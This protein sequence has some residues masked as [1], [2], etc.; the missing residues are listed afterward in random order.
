MLNRTPPSRCPKCGET[1]QFG[2]SGMSTGFGPNDHYGLPERAMRKWIAENSDPDEFGTVP[3]PEDHQDG[4]TTHA[5]YWPDCDHIED[6]QC[7]KDESVM[8]TLKEY[9]G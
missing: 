9:S 1:P 3:I 8:W 6:C 7:D 2:S 5:T 4:L